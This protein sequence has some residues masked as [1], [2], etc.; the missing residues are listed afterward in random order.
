MKRKFQGITVPYQYYDYKKNYT[1]YIYK[2]KEYR[3]LGKLFKAF[4]GSYL[5][6]HFE[7][8]EKEVEVHNLSEVLDNLLKFPDTFKIPSKYK[9]EYSST[10]YEYIKGLK[11]AINKDKL[12]VNYNPEFTYSIKDFR[13]PKLFRFA[14]DIDNRYNNVVI[15]KKIKSTIYDEEYY[16]VGGSAY[17][18][19][20]YALDVVYEGELHYIFGGTKNPN[21]RTREQ[22]H[23]FDDLISLIFKKSNK[24]VIH[25]YQQEY[26]SKQEL[27]FLQKLAD[28][29]NEIGYRSVEPKYEAEYTEDYNYLKDH[30]RYI[31]LLI[32]N[33]KFHL[34]QKK[35]E[36]QVLKSHKI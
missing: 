12:K 27:E 33:I 31:G 35:H 32:N 36:R 18:S 30:H 3:D 28:K 10:E 1:Y 6:Y 16:V 24:F 23:N 17:Q 5:T 14:R 29:I 4:I 26:Y 21:N 7:V 11:E 9:D 15:P 2:D 22:A 8:R 34:K 20:Y 19:I 25:V 13:S